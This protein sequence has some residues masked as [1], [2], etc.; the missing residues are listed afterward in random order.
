MGNVEICPLEGK[1][2]T[3][4]L[5]VQIYIIQKLVYEE[6]GHTPAYKEANNI[7]H[8]ANDKWIN[9]PGVGNI[10]GSLTWY[11]ESNFF[12]NA[13][14]MHEVGHNWLLKHAA[15]ASVPEG[16]YNDLSSSMG[17]CCSTRCY[18]FIHNYQ[19]GW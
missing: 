9:A 18:H 2:E 17:I 19:L 10:G 4:D 16:P 14:I 15:A 11:Q 5:D 3:N 6:I 1:C 12:S 13:M 7:F 8:I